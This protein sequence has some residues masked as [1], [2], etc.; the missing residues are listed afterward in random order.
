MN[1]LE[2][3]WRWYGDA[4]ASLR[5]MERIGEK[6]WDHLS[7][8]SPP[9]KG[10]RHFFE[11]EKE[12]VVASAANGRGHLDDIAV[13]VLFSVFE[14]TVRRAVLDQIALEEGGLRHRSI[15]DA[16]QAAKDR[17]REGSFFAVLEPFKPLDAALIEE[18]NQVRRFRNWVSHGKRGEQ[19]AVVSP[20][21]AYDRLNRCLPLL[22]S[23]PNDEASTEPSR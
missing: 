22:V 9:W 16:I 2:D 13:V 23:P 6:W 7:W 10:D 21:V 12:S 11:L 15:V 1:D 20:R 17:I 3:A 4:L 18:V 19:P 5:R 8:E 14:A